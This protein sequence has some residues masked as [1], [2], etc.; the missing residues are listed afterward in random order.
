VAA[1]FRPETLEKSISG[2]GR[3]KKAFPVSED[4]K[5][6]KIDD[7]IIFIY[8]KQKSTKSENEQKM[9]TIKKTEKKIVRIEN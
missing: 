7:G 5:S 4:E 8:I 3:R 6:T 9:I 2:F 1:E